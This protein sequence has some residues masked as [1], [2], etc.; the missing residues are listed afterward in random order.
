MTSA[1]VY[2][3]TSLDGYIARS[4]GGIDWLVAF[5][6]D[7]AVDA[8]NEFMAA[9]DVIVIGRGTFD[10]V[11]GFPAWPYDKPVFVLRHT[12]SE[13]P[14]S[15]KGKAEVICLEPADLLRHLS[16]KGFKAAYIDGGKVIQGFLAEGLID[17][18]TIAKVPVLIG[19]GL[20]LFG[21]LDRDVAF[22]HVRTTVASNGLVRS[23]YERKRP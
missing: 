2:I 16:E 15:V 3:G 1:H 13:L 12:L 6:D 19:S 17:T 4:A 18:L 7:E 22:D 5:A 21:I 8:Y 10:T 14:E 9:I 23:Y 20:P 11:L